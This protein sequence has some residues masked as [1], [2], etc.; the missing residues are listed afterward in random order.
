MTTHYQN[1]FV[2]KTVIADFF[3]RIRKW[4]KITK[5]AKRTKTRF[6]THRRSDANDDTYVIFFNL[7]RR[8]IAIMKNFVNSIRTI[9]DTRLTNMTHL[10]VM[11]TTNLF[12]L[13][14]P[15]RW[16]RA[17][18]SRNLPRSCA[19]RH[20]FR[21]ISNIFQSKRLYRPAVAIYLSSNALCYQPPAPIESFNTQEWAL[22]LHR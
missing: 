5:I 22:Y 20:E 9:V 11:S 4:I 21:P 14:G 7:F 18:R 17:K 2:S 10:Y 13:E 19:P 12:H 15:F 1:E 6:E 16:N 8:H 3:V